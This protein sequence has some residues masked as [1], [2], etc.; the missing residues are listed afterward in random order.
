M[1]GGIGLPH[2]LIGDFISVATGQRQFLNVKPGEWGLIAA[3]IALLGTN[4]MVFELAEVVATAGF[5]SNI[6]T[7]K[8][9]YLWLVTLPVTLIMASTYA[10]VVDRVKRVQ[11]MAYMLAI[12]AALYFITLLMF[13]FEVV[14]LIKFSVLY[15]ITELQYA[16]FPLAFWSL[17]NDQFTLSDTR[18]LFPL[19]ATGGALGSIAGNLLASGFTRLF[20]DS[21]SNA[22][23]V[24]LVG[25]FIFLSGLVVLYFAFRNRE[26]RARTA[27]QSDG[28]LTTIKEGMDVIRGVPLFRYLALAMMLIGLAF[29]IIE[30]HFLYALDTASQDENAAPR[31]FQSFYGIYK[32]VMIGGVLVFQSLISGRYLE[33]A[34]T[35]NSFTLLPAMVLVGLGIMLAFVSPINYLAV[36]FGRLIMRITQRGWDE[37][38]R[39]S[40]QALVPDERR[41]RVSTFMDNYFYTLASI[42]GSLIVAGLLFLRDQEIISSETTIYIY[43]GV[44]VIATIGAIWAT[45]RLRILYDKSL[46]N[47]RLSRS[48][49]KSVLDGIEF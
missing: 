14:D 18:R 27:R 10:L 11:L 34:G 23:Q 29:V 43:L 15:T 3:L 45:L 37:P 35:K 20:P 12:F 39:K 38:A 28:P 16:I 13:E 25:V 5:I 6:G 31:F 26:V 49:R 1:E 19:I 9:I 41:G 44:A 21:D 17:A 4:A 46:L 8:I 47:W 48:K 36:A 32:A 22:P 24:L 42:L 7:P 40:A 30:F 33:K 2:N